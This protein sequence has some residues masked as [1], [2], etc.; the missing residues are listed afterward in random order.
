V[1]DISEEGV[2]I[3]SRLFVK[4]GDAL[5]LTIELARGGLLTCE[6]KVVHVRSPRLGAKIVLISPQDRER[7]STIL[8]DHVQVSFTR[9]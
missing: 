7:L 9:H 2:R 6:L 1:L 5:Q 8:D 4:K 3:E